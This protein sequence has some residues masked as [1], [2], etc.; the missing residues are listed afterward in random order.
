MNR[1]LKFAIPIAAGILAIS[2]GAGVLAAKA[3][4]QNITYVPDSSYQS[5]GASNAAITEDGWYCPGPGLM[6]DLGIG[7]PVTSQVAALLDTTVT[8]LETQLSSGKTLADIASTKGIT[9]D[10]LI[11]TLI[12][13]YKDHLNLMV[14]KSYISQDQ[15]NNLLQ[16]AQERIQTIIT[17]PLQT[18][19]DYGWGLMGG[20]MSGWNYSPQ[21]GTDATPNYGLGGMMGGHGNGMMG[22]YGGGMM[23]VW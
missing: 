23:G 16:Q 5:T 14:S 11:Q 6:M 21:P 17:S 7:Y 12:A 8:D 18:G 4:D 1:K 20:M 2:T 9:Q 19:Y 3:A 15:E 22:G 10:Q 13:P